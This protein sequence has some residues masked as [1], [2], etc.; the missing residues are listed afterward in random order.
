MR[1]AAVSIPRYFWASEVRRNPV[2]RGRPVIVGDADPPKHVLDCSPEAERH[3]ITRGASVRQ[4]ISRCPGGLVLAPDFPYYSDLWNE[5]LDTLETISPEVEDGRPGL[6]Y[7]NVTGLLPH[8][9]GDEVILSAAISDSLR[10]TTGL[11]PAVGIATNKAVALVAA[12]SSTDK[13][14]V[15]VG[16]GMEAGFLASRS[17]SALP[18]TFALLERL[19]LLGLE[20]IGQVAALPRP[21]LGEQFGPEGDWLW[22]LANGIDSEP[23]RPRQ[24]AVI[25]E[26][27]IRFEGAVAGVEVLVAAARQLVGRLVSRLEGRAGRELCLRAELNL[28]RGWERRI[29]LREAVSEQERLLFIVKTALRERPPQAAVVSL[30]VS[31]KGLSGETGRQLAIGEKRWTDALAESIQQIKARDGHSHLFHCVE[32]EPWSVIP[33]RRFLLVEYDA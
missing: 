16:P 20:R 12:S 8:Y 28:G 15:I 1:I 18:L 30:S 23:L 25:L 17:L 6:A 11:T 27:S 31:L 26:E 3:G 22:V 19:H 4:A 7:L 13:E 5:A 33:E 2:L 14:P 24:P 32:V 9:A 10:R 29:V 21:R